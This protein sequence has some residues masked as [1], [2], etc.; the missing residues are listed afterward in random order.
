MMVI[1]TVVVWLLLVVQVTVSGYLVV[2]TVCANLPR[3][4][5]RA[6]KYYHEYRLSVV[7]PAH[8]EEALLPRLLTCLER[9][10]YRRDMF[11]VHV[12]ADNCTDGTAEVAMRFNAILHKRQVPESPGKGQAI[13]W[14]LPHLL[15]SDSDAFVFV[16]ADSEV[17]PWFLETMNGYLARGFEALQA[18][19]R[20]IAPDSSP[21]RSLRGLALGLMH[22]LRGRGKARLGISAGIWGNGVVLR[23]ELLGELGWRSFSSV[24]DAEQHVKLILGGH[25]VQ[26][27]PEA[28]VYGD[29]PATFKAARSQQVRWE[30]G[31]LALVRSYGI[32]LLKQAVLTRDVSVACTL[33]ELALPPLS[34]LL[35]LELVI[36]GLAFQLGQDVQI[37]VVSLAFVGLLTYV[38]SGFRFAGLKPRSYLGLAYA[39]AYILWKASLYV[40]EFVRR[41]DSRWVRTVRE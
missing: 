26:F 9:Q 16:D 30:A 1:G 7:I 4:R 8:N 28:S 19:Y 6:R 21:L 35:V 38:V 17:D 13:A 40:R 34:L 15:E 10:T 23:R 37:V 39:P 18:S 5:L 14:L 33:I 20:V 29:M 12:L 22:E 36:T 25:S 27:V 41:T 32:R 31:R 11:A 2:L 3:K 24:E